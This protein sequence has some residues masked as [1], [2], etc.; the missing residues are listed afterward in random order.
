MNDATITSHVGHE[1]PPATLLLYGPRDTVERPARAIHREPRNFACYLNAPSVLLDQCPEL[2]TM[3][4]AASAAQS[5]DVVDYPSSPPT[6]GDLWPHHSSVT[7]VPG[8]KLAFALPMLFSSKITNSQLVAW[9]GSNSAGVLPAV[10]RGVHVDALRKLNAQRGRGYPLRSAR[11]AQVG[12]W[13]DRA[14]GGWTCVCC[15]RGSGSHCVFSYATPRPHL[16]H[17]PRH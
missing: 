3:L 9:K 17:R 6:I 13:H 4:G 10:G 16:V 14:V 1:I 5:E 12:A 11:G 2:M 15:H 8:D 7:R